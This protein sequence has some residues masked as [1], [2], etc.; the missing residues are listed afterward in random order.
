MHDKKLAEAI[1]LLADV[2]ANAAKQR[3][4]EFEWLKAHFKFATKHDLELM[5]SRIMSVISDFGDRVT[6]K[7]D[8]LGKAVDGVAAD[9]AFLKAKIEELQ[10]NPGPITPADQAILDA[11]EAR[12]GTLSDKVKALDAATEE[13]PVPPAA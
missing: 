7:F 1:C 4:A 9:V 6:A 12:V 5:E 11:L 13:P 10:N 3:A 8:E 2:T